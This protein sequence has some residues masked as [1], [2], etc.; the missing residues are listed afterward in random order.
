MIV[1][2]YVGE[3]VEEEP[4]FQYIPESPR[5]PNG[6][7]EKNALAESIMLLQDGLESGTVLQQF[8]VN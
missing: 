6:V 3:E 5:V 7:P 1:S 8:E 2:V 4:I